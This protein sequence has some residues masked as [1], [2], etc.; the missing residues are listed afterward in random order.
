M[1]TLLVIGIMISYIC[2]AITDLCITF[3]NDSD[4]AN[5]TL[6]NGK[7][8]SKFMEYSKII[9]SYSISDSNSDIPFLQNQSVLIFLVKDM[10]RAWVYRLNFFRLCIITLIKHTFS[11]CNSTCRTDF[12]CGNCSSSCYAYSYENVK[13]SS[14]NAGYIFKRFG[15]LHVLWI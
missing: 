1:S 8:F 10:Q 4:I 15:I 6:G 12:F 11:M 7:F 2:S 14:D 13:T 5:L 9:G 3:A